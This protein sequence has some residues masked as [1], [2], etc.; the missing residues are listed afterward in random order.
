MNELRR[1][2]TPWAY[3]TPATLLPGN[4]AQ[5]STLHRTAMQIRFVAVFVAYLAGALH[6][7]RRIPPTP[8][9]TPATL[10]ALWAWGPVAGTLALPHFDR[11]SIIREPS[12]HGGNAEK[13]N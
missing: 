12:T 8:G 4:G 11:L 5:Y 9:R 10:L 13:F 7:V 3:D 6:L 2:L 1:W